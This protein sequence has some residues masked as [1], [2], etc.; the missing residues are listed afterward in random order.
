MHAVICYFSMLLCCTFGCDYFFYK[1]TIP[2]NWRNSLWS[3]RNVILFQKIRLYEAT[4]SPPVW[5]NKRKAITASVYI[6][7][8]FFY[9]I[10]I[11]QNYIVLNVPLYSIY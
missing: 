3:V 6:L 10:N 8:I 11:F 2:Q 7:N 1:N 9:L 4:N 5:F